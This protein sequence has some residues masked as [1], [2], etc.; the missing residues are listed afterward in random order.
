MMAS[1]VDGDG[2]V[3]IGE[4]NI[5]EVDRDGKV[6]IGEVNIGEIDIVEVDI[7]E[8]DVGEVTIGEVNIGEIGIVEVDISE[9]DVGEVG[10]NRILDHI[11]GDIYILAVANP[12]RIG[13]PGIGRGSQ[14]L[15]TVRD[16]EAI[17][18]ISAELIFAGIVPKCSAFSL[19]IFIIN[20]VVM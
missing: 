11:V 1:W 14:S 5:D 16:S 2:E 20:I 13:L 9:I 3:T 18:N 17:P 8:I 19:V 7:S 12:G 4:V 15:P 6:T 10:H